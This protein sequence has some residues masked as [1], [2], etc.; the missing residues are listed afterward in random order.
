MRD[1]R[2]GLLHLAF[3]EY[4]AAIASALSTKVDL[5]VLHP[6]QQV[7]HIRPVLPAGVKTKVFNKPRFRDPSNIFAMR[8]LVRQLREFDLIHVQ[9]SGDPWVDLALGASVAKK[10]VVTVHDVVPHSGDGDRIPGSFQARRML[11]SRAAGLIVHTES[12]AEQLREETAAPIAV[13][14]HPSTRGSFV[15]PNRAVV[16]EPRNRSQ[17]LFFGR[18]WPYK[19][20]DLLI[21]AM[22]KV[23]EKVPDASL[24]IAGRGDL[25][26]IHI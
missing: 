10:T 1:A 25:S 22:Y 19:G 6:V 5:T 15:P 21:D 8:S 4:T 18:I 12:M 3:H 17:V 11:H 23:I 9:Q 24:V 14:P 13:I 26:L 16:R 20:L 7:D 2:V